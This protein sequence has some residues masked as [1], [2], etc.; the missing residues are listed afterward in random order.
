LESATRVTMNPGTPYCITVDETS[1]TAKDVTI[2]DRDTTKQIR[3]K[4]QKIVRQTLRD[5]I[6]GKVLF[7]KAGM[8]VR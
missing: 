8:L 3:V 6:E 4:D 2:R 5:L 1:P 7:E